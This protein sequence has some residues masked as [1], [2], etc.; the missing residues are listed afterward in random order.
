LVLP[1]TCGHGS[2]SQELKEEH[3]ALPF[4]QFSAVA[5]QGVLVQTLAVADYLSFH[6]AAKTLGTSQS[7]VSLA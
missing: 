5:S 2:A 3:L 6:R 1:A 7:S 4:P